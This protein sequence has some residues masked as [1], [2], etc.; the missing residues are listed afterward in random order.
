MDK[1]MKS[2]IKTGYRLQ[3]ATKPPRFSRILET[4]L[5]SPQQDLA[6]QAELQEL[7]NKEV[8]SRVPSGEEYEGFYSR[9][10][11][12][13]KKTGAMR[14]I[15]DLSFFNKFI[16]KRPF[17]MLTTKQ[18]LTCV[19][20]GDWFTSINLKD[21]YFHVPVI[22][23]HRKYLR[24][25]FQE[26][27]Y[28][29]NHLPFG[30]ALTPRIFSKCVETAL[31]PLRSA[32]MRI[33][34]YLDDLL[35]LAPSRQ[36]AASQTEKLSAHLRMLGFSINWKKSSLIPAQSS[37]YLGVDLN[38]VT[39]TAHLSLPKKRLLS[40]LA[41]VRPRT[42]VTAL[43]IMRLLGMMTAAHAVV[44]L[45]LLHTRP[46]QRCFSRLKIDP[47]RHKR[48][49]VSI[50]S[51]VEA[52]LSHWRKPHTLSAGVPLSRATHHVPVF[53]NTSLSGW[54]G[55]CLSQTVG[56]HWSAHPVPHINVLELLT[57]WKVLVH[58]IHLV[59]DQHVLVHMDNKAAAASINRLG[60]VRSRLLLDTAREL[61]LWAH[62]H[63]R[64]IRAVYFLGVLNKG[65]DIMSRGGP[66]DG[67]WPLHKT[68]IT[69]IWDRFGKAEVD[70]FASRENTQ[71]D[72]W[73]S[74]SS[75]DNPPLGVDAFAHR[76]WPNKLLYAFPPVPL[77][78]RL[79][80]RIRAD[81]RRAILIALERTEAHWFP[82]LQSLLS[83]LPLQLPWQEN[84][85]LQAGGA[86]RSYLRLG[87]PLWA[88][89]LNGNA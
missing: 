47:I 1:W 38:S 57:V 27:Q 56:D 4:H 43:T 31:Q 68:I 65:A 84:T 5:S 60:G 44:P 52:D 62:T 29:Y 12:V 46:L 2:L 53:T 80:D 20:E 87:Q 40:L 32:G 69:Q 71:C 3:F 24:F 7:L 81:R 6:L 55:T 28:Q 36:E 64:S 23:A 75:Q 58:L 88:W 9:Y 10:F 78:P 66:Q 21:A 22:P 17:H 77:I 61:L 54:G 15:L 83:G 18:M 34:F 8:I 74:L 73:F 13:P 67:D 35:L 33:L 42:S 39:M 49:I 63:L 11:L 25:S 76:P 41:H 89:P 86:I 30:Y 51:S 82:V 14:P 45:G 26:I 50:P 70:L 19:Q 37:T 48:R 79:L 59:R 16:L 72:L 85:L